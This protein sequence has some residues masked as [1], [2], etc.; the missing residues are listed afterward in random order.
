MVARVFDFQMSINGT[1]IPPVNVLVDPESF[2]LEL[3]IPD[4]VLQD[5]PARFHIRSIGFISKKTNLFPYVMSEPTKWTEFE[6]QN[7]DANIPRLR[8]QPFWTSPA[9]VSKAEVA[10]NS[11]LVIHEGLVPQGPG[12][13]VYWTE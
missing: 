9:E 5:G 1:I 13:L 11:V 7:V 12:C 4:R 2:R 3:K 10:D 6:F 8:Y